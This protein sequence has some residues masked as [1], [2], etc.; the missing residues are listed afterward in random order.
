M[1]RPSLTRFAWLSIA[2]AIVTIGLKVA[3]YRVTGSVGLLSDALESL[4]NLAAA[5]M[6]LAM[7][8]VAARPPDED[9]VYGHDKAEYFSSGVEGALILVAAIS[10]GVTAW[11]RLLAPQPL[12]GLG[13]GLGISLLASLI[14]LGVA[15]VL[16]RAGQRYS[17]ITLDADAQH[18]MTD[19]W[20]SVGVLAGIGAVALT[21]WERLDPIIAFAVAL[22]IIWSGV[23]LVRRSALGLLDT[24]WP[25]PERSVVANIL[26]RYQAQGVQFH[27]LRTRQSAARR[28]MSVHVLVPGD[29][30]VLRG[31]QLLEKLEREVREALTGV[32][33]L[34]HLEPLEDPVSW[35]DTQLDRQTA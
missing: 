20:T 35:E 19:V 24:A 32:T 8:T 29:W 6:A 25:A 16:R 30:T 10:I 34:T 12:E 17:S 2:A 18:L 3:A 27:A 22:N 14:N 7:L 9:H 1:Q 15:L 33:I 4:V 26:D 23:Q 11:N 21:G 28:F 5:L 13:L 31:H